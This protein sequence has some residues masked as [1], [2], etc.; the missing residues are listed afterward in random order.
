MVRYNQETKDQYD[1]R[2]YRRVARLLDS[3][4]PRGW[5]EPEKRKKLESPWQF[6]D[7]RM[8]RIAQYLDSC[9]HDL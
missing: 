3:I 4:E 9:C 2:F 8:R 6:P 1:E 5:G 7:T